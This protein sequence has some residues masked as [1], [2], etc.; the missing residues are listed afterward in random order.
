MSSIAH[1]DANRYEKARVEN[2]TT[3]R[4]TKMDTERI[5]KIRFE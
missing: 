4:D 1:G 3:K 5:W 2:R